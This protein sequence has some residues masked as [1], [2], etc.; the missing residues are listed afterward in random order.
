[1]SQVTIEYCARCDTPM[2]PIQPC[3]LQCMNCGSHLDCSD[4]GSYW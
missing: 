3:H 2:T 1:M 4:K